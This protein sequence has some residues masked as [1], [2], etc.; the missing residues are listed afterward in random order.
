MSIKNVEDYIEELQ[1]FFPQIEE[2]ELRRMVTKMSL[3]VTQY[4]KAGHKGLRI[5]SKQSLGIEEG[6]NKRPV[7]YIE[8]IF[9]K[10]HLNSMRKAA[11]TRNKKRD[12]LYGKEE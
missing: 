2:E 4:F 7:F 12:E 9:G 1:G 6:S 10:K 3:D 11:R 5:A 8:R